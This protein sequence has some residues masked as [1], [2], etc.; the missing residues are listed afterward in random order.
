MS[1]AFALPFSDPPVADGNHSFDPKPIHRQ[2]PSLR[3]REIFAAVV[4][5]K[6][7][8]QAAAEFKLTQ[9]RVTQ[10]VQQV[11]DWMN[12]VTRG[13]EFDYTEVQRLRV[14]EETLRIQLDGWMRMAMQEWFKS[15]KESFGRTTFL[16]QAARLSANLARL[17][18]VDVTGK[19]AR[20]LAEQQDRTERLLRA[21]RAEKTLWDREPELADETSPSTAAAD[22]TV[23]PDDVCDMQDDLELENLERDSGQKNSYG[24]ASPVSRSQIAGCIPLP[25]VAAP[26]PSFPIPPHKPIPKFLDKKS[27][28]RLRAMRRE[29][30]R[31]QALVE[32]G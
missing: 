18:G 13:E 3:N 20:A 8:A 26:E 2:V 16:S 25:L 19:T 5:G 9:P 17:A 32:A 24:L 11:R 21:Q 22:A 28:K 23:V 4:L 10:I 12:Q 14:A 7:H 6:S 15:C 30:A 27:R 31:A 29:Q 1:A